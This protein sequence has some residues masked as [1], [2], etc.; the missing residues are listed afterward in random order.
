MKQEMNVICLDKR[1]GN[2]TYGK[3][4]VATPRGVMVYTKEPVDYEITDDEGD[5]YIIAE[6]KHLLKK[7]WKWTD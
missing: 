1:Y 7:N 2:F 6:R 5:L 3:T 4:Y